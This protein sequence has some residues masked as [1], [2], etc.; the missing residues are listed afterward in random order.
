VPAEEDLLKTTEVA[1]LLR[2]HPKHVY[3]LLA[4]GLPGRRVGSEWRFLRDEVLAWSAA[5]GGIPEAAAPAHA[6]STA[7]V[8][9]PPGPT[10]LLAANGDVVIELLLGLA[11]RE[12]K[13]LVG[14]VQS[15]RGAALDRLAGR[16]ILA[17]GFHGERAPVELAAHRLARLH[18]VVREIGLAHAHGTKLRD[19][20]GLAKKRL[21]TRPPTAGVRGHLDRALAKAGLALDKLRVAATEVGSHRD[22]VCAVVRGEADVALTTTAWAARVGLDVLPLGREEYELLMFAD[23]LGAPAAVGLCELAQ[24]GAFRRALAGV[25]GYDARDAGAIRYVDR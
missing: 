4:Q 16:E 13:P 22:A 23:T 5:R 14:F 24:G 11:L 2:V 6:L 3:R 17:A 9:P 18:L 15:D 21:A 1:K 19:L 20:S 25:A 10:P 8:E 12:R 7:R